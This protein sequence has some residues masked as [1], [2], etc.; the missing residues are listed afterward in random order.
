MGARSDGV[1]GR[2]EQPISVGR[3]TRRVVDAFLAH[4]LSAPVLSH[5]R[6]GP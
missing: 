1:M 5:T 4:R 2:G 3:K 6:D